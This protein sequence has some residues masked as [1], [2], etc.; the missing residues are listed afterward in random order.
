MLTF[1]S[2]KGKE[3]SDNEKIAHVSCWMMRPSPIMIDVEPFSMS[4][5][6]KSLLC[7]EEIIAVNQD[8]LGMPSS[9][10]YSDEKWSVQIKP[11]AD[12]TYALAYFNLGEETALSP[13]LTLMFRQPGMYYVLHENPTF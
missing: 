3:L 11:L 5:F 7:N 4:E 2:R 9:P 1:T 12:N 6:E 10:I 13:D 8:R